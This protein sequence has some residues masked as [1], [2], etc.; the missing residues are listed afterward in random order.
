ME[1]TANTT[2]VL[3][4]KDVIRSFNTALDTMNKLESNGIIGEGTV[5]EAYTLFSTAFKDV[6]VNKYLALVVDDCL[7]DGTPLEYSVHIFDDDDERHYFLDGVNA[8]CRELGVEEFV[9]L[10]PY[11]W[12]NLHKYKTV[13]DIVTFHDCIE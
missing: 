13:N 9:K 10:S 11:D 3:S 4:I 2:K 8:E 7:K 1:N 5:L 6:L 12:S